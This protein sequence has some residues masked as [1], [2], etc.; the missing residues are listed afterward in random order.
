MLRSLEEWLKY[1][2]LCC[3]TLAIGSVCAV[4]SCGYRC[5][6]SSQGRG[7]GAAGR[8][9]TAG[10]PRIGRSSLMSGQAHRVRWRRAASL[11]R[12]VGAARSS[13]PAL[14]HPVCVPKSD[15]T[16]LVVKSTEN[17]LRNAR[18]LFRPADVRGS[19]RTAFKRRRDYSNK[20]R[21][22]GVCRLSSFHRCDVVS[23]RLPL[24]TATPPRNQV[25]G[26]RREHFWE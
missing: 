18:V 3:K 20:N 7:R 25:W 16:I 21:R 24:A 4:A 8:P 15:S 22:R 19:Y 11:G 2:R 13:A 6:V 23:I 12:G 17:R 5:S 1:P 10:C 9:K 14:R 26:L